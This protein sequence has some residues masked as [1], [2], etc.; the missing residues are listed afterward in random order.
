MKKNTSSMILPLL[1]G[2]A[3][4]YTVSDVTMCQSSDP[5][6]TNLKAD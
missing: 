5:A 6:T 3:Y 4:N 1:Q 2:Q